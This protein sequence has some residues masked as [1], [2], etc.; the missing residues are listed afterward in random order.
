MTMKPLLKELLNQR[1]YLTT[2]GGTVFS[3]ELETIHETG[4]LT[5]REDK[6]LV[7]V[8]LDAIVAVRR[9][10]PLHEIPFR[11]TDADA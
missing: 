11:R 8:A 2:A 7:D 4:T 9:K 5:L 3:G 6:D 10:A 1:V